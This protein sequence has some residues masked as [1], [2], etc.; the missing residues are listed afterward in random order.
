MISRATLAATAALALAAPAAAQADYAAM[1]SDLSAPIVRTEFSLVPEDVNHAEDYYARIGGVAKLLTSGAGSDG[2]QHLWRASGDG[3]IAYFRTSD[4][5]VA[6]DTDAADDLYVRRPS[7]VS[8]I[9]PQAGPIDV[10]DLSADGSRAFL[11]TASALLPADTDE[12]VDI[13]RYA[14]AT[15]ELVLLTP[16]T[17]AN[18]AF[19][20]S[21]EGSGAAIVSTVDPLA[22]GDG[23][24]ERDVYLADGGQLGLIS[25]GNGPHALFAAFGADGQILY[26]TNEALTADDKDTEADLYSTGGGGVAQ[27]RTPSP[28]AAAG[29]KP[30]SVLAA[31]QDDMHRVIFSTTEKLVP[32]DTDD[33]EDYY[34]HDNGDLTLLTPFTGSDLVFE[35]VSTDAE[36][37]LF[38]SRDKLMPT[39]TDDRMDMYRSGDFGRVHV[40]KTNGPF[41]EFEGALSFNGVLTA[42]QTAEPISGTDTDTLT[43][44]YRLDKGGVHLMSRR[45]PAA[46]GGTEDH[47]EV[48]DF[49]A[50]SELIMETPERLLAEDRNDVSDVYSIGFGALSMVTRDDSAPDTLAGAPAQVLPGEAFAVTVAATETG[51]LECRLDEG[52]WVACASG[53]SPGGLAAGTHTVQARATDAALNVDATP[54]TATVIAAAAT[55]PPSGGGGQKPPVAGSG[56]PQ[57]PL[58][59]GA[60]AV[61]PVISKA[62]VRV[63]RRVPA[64]TFSLTEKASVTVTV[65]RRS[66]G[67]WKTLRR[68]VLAGTP[69]ANRAALPKLPRRGSFRFALVATDAAGHASARLVLRPKGR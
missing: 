64:L 66:G 58:L 9:A 2:G 15:G 1:T 39:D 11:R 54:A 7:G 28:N 4:A 29:A 40:S 17:T 50:T 38:S 49:L 30:V 37:L 21:Q 69:G 61:A 59:P 41:D 14:S 62:G 12:N 23:D 65:Q 18:V 46:T 33:L 63:R 35:D 27:L 26:R 20:D 32:G 10:A 31:S 47:A 22:P 45:D 19:H 16:G 67:R 3:S 24:F 5:L 43:D 53:W 68:K 57:P 55:T 44:V 8:V 36:V 48:R 60:D 34:A 56:T 52:A 25:A 13:Y 51:T 42:F 6:E